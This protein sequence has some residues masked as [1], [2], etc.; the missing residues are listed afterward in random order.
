MGFLQRISNR[1]TMAG[2]REQLKMKKVIMPFF[3]LILLM[4]SCGRD[5]ASD[6]STDINIPY[7]LK[8]RWK[9]DTQA[10]TQG[11]VIHN[12]QLYEGTGQENSWI[13]IV[14]IKT[15]RPD[16]KVV[17]DREYF[18]EGITILNNKLYQLTWK[19]NIGFIY[20]VRT[21]E[22]L[23]EFTYETEGWG[24][25]HDGT[26]LI[27]SDGTEKL[28][29]LDTTTLKPVRTLRVTD[30]RGIVTNLNELEYMEGFILANQWETNRVL[31]IDPSTGKV[32]GVL[33]LTPLARDAKLEYSNS[34]VLNGIAYH[35]STKL[36]IVTGKYWPWCYVLQLNQNNNEQ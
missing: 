20:D 21:F 10:W 29:Y 30:E 3:I 4:A 34:N 12:G 14:D 27:M 25:T 23:G 6:A 17:L 18:G 33:D 16:K 35:P 28:I 15:G 8:T 9:H 32:V 5:N 19:H 24:L 26:N 13:G 22:K 7:K 1:M 2:H 36:L 11:L 31:K